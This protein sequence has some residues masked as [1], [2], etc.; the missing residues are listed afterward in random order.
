VV[1]SRRELRAPTLG[2][3]LLMAFPWQFALSAMITS[4][5]I[6]PACTQERL[7]EAT[8]HLQ[9]SGRSSDWVPIDCLTFAL[10]IGEAEEEWDNPCTFALDFAA[11]PVH[12]FTTSTECTSLPTL[13]SLER[14]CYAFAQRLH[15]RC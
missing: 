2:L 7:D 13:I 10:V 8:H 1:S 12:G 5:D 14:S 4:A 11:S 6:S 9:L 3:V 15:L